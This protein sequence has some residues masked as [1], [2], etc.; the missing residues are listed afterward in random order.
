MRL[1]RNVGIAARNLFFEMVETDF[2]LTLDDDS[3]PRSE[4]DVLRLLETMESDARI[5]SVCAS[6]VHPETGVAETRGIERFA[7]RGSAEEGYDVVNIA[8]G[9][10]LLRMTAMR[11]THGYGAEFFWGRE[12]NDLAFQLLQRGWRVLYDP[13]AVIWHTLSPTGR[14]ALPRLRAVTR[15]SFWLLWKYFP[16][17]VAL[18]MAL[19]FA[20]RR[21]L[22]LLKSPQRAG[23][24]FG[25]I[26]DG[27]SGM[28][29]RRRSS[30]ETRHFTL[31]ES[32]A[33]RGWFRKLLSE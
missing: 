26:A 22:P 27:W 15:N 31:R 8:A 6:C 3:W 13:R 16:L 18:P 7:S 5:A 32:W 21:M 14:Q 10:S 25:G 17:P 1:E 9:G 4:E 33:L 19:L 20:L 11:E 30:G 24:V 29:T 28:T 23:A 12:E 2:L